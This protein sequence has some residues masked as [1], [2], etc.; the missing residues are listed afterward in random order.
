MAPLSLLHVNVPLLEVASFEVSQE[1]KSFGRQEDPGEELRGLAAIG[2]RI[3]AALGIEV[4][5]DLL[6][7][8][9]AQ[10]VLV[11]ERVQRLPGFEKERIS[12]IA[13]GS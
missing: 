2:R 13:P 8:D 11:V 1:E 4:V 12:D 7:Y 10:I 6:A 9:Q 3:L 5:P